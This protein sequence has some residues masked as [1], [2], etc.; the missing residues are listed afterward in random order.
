MLEEIDAD[1]DGKAVATPIAICRLKHDTAALLLSGSI[2]FLEFMEKFAT[3]KMTGPAEIWQQ[4]GEMGWAAHW[5]SFNGITLKVFD[6]SSAP[7]ERQ[8]ASLRSACHRC[9]A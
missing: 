4:K 9:P 5:L 1:H 2:D 6:G 7:G 3:L 8:P